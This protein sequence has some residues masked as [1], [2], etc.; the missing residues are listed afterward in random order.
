MDRVTDVSG[1]GNG[2]IF[3]SIDSGPWG[4]LGVMLGL[5]RRITYLGRTRRWFDPDGWLV[6]DDMLID[7]LASEW[8]QWQLNQVSPTVTEE[9]LS[10]RY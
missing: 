4:W 9:Q 10:T 3:V 1:A 5:H 6:Q 8:R 2:A 7:R